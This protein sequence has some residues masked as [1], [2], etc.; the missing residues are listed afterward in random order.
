[1]KQR[2]DA[3]QDHRPVEIVRKR[4]DALHAEQMRPVGRTQQVNEHFK[5]RRVDRPVVR[6]GEGADARVVPVDR[7]GDGDDGDA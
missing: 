1:M 5:R 7:H 2:L 6:Q 4:H 3:V